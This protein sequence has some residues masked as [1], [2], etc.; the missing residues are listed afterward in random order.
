MNAP[1]K[2][3]RADLTLLYPLRLAANFIV[4][5]NHTT[6]NALFT[7]QIVVYLFLAIMFGLA[8]SSSRREPLS[9]FTRKKASLLLV[10]WLRWSLVYVALAIVVG[11]WKGSGP[12]EKLDWKMLLYGGHAD[13]WFL[14]F[15]A[16]AIVIAKGLQRLIDRF[17]PR[18]TV[19]LLCVAAVVA[20]HVAAR[21]YFATSPIEPVDAWMRSSPMILWGLAIGESRRASGKGTR[22]ALLACAAAL[23]LLALFVPP[24]REIPG[25]VPIGSAVGVTLVA[26]GFAW[27]PPI[28][29]SVKFAAGFTYGIYLLHPLIAKIV[30]TALPALHAGPAIVNVLAVWLLSGLSIYALRRMSVRWSECV[31]LR[32]QAS[33]A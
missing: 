31:D 2:E 18:A 27:S 13:L 23:S 22:R 25:G 3:D 24:A 32:A 1:P 9:E 21:V 19:P 15:A 17:D 7:V 8:T 26:I 6:A 4:V 33:G 28:P 16:V 11:A 20:T 12:F 29:R 5:W 14:P 30:A 10:P